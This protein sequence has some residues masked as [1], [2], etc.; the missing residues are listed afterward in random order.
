MKF[1]GYSVDAAGL[2]TFEYERDGARFLETIVPEGQGL[3]RKFQVTATQPIT[4]TLDPA[5]TCASGVQ[6][7]ETLT[8]TP[9]QAKSFTLNVRL[10]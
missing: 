2:P 8:L 10:P 6:L 3:A 9:A 7:N 5:T 1:L 4:L